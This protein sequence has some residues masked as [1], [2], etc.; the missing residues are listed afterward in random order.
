MKR[1]VA[2]RTFGDPEIGDVLGNAL[3][4]KESDELIALR[5]EVQELREREAKYGVRKVRDKAYFSGKML[6]LKEDNVPR[7]PGR[8]GQVMLIA[9]AMTALVLVE[10]FKRLDEWVMNSARGV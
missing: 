7:K 4:P 6:E 9:W 5:Q 2:I 1:A 10:L 3:V 8:V